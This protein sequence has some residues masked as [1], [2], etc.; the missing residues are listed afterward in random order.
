MELLVSTI[1][2]YLKFGERVDKTSKIIKLCFLCTHT[3]IYA[4]AFFLACSC[5]S[6]GTK[7]GTTCQ[8]LGG[9]CHCK[10][11]VTGQSCDQCKPGFF[12]FTD[13][14][15]TGTLCSVK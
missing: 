13:S 3:S 10:P 12:N 2:R 9:Q 8:Q 11:G 7:N 5:N 15:C 6:T 4:A 1:S 14:G